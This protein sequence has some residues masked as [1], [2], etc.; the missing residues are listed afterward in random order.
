[1]GKTINR[2]IEMKLSELGILEL[3][4]FDKLDYSLE[5]IGLGDLFINEL[6]YILFLNDF[7]K[8]Q[9]SEI[10]SIDITVSYNKYKK[11]TYELGKYRFTLLTNSKD[12]QKRL[13]ELIMETDLNFSIE[14][15][16]IKKNKD[17][18]WER[19]STSITGI[20]TTKIEELIV[21]IEEFKK[22]L[23]QVKKEELEALPEGFQDEV[24]I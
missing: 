11:I 6:H 3:E 23:M 18:Y 2:F 5:K 10:G 13:L 4:Q 19:Y 8:E 14:I 9:E 21:M 16:K 17:M 20:E 7:S 12:R 15:E 24:R 1:M 22:Y